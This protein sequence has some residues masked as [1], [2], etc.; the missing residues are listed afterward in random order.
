MSDPVTLHEM[1]ESDAPAVQHVADAACHAVYDD[2]LGQEMADHI[3]QNWYD[4][5]R[6]VRDDIEPEERPCFVAEADGTVVGFIEGI[7]GDE[8]TADLYRI[9]VHPD[10]WGEG[11]GSALLDRLEAR[12]QNEGFER[13][14][15]SVLADNE[16]GVAFYESVGFEHVETTQDEQFEVPRAEYV[17]DLS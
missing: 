17:K 8:R 10:Y 3:V 13:L 6:L 7:P 14:F 2:I 15:V 1:T 12:F 11:V 9:Y 4:P 5:E 16:V